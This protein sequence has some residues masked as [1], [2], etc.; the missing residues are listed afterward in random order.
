MTNRARACSFPVLLAMLVTG[1]AAAGSMPPAGQAEAGECVVLLH[2]LAR[3]KRSMARAEEIVRAYGYATVNVG[4]ASRSQ[5]VAKL[6]EA[7]VPAGVE[8]C[9]SRGARR[10]HFLAHSLGGILVRYHLSRHRIPE[11]GRVVMLAPP[12]QG[13]EAVDTLSGVPGYSLWYGPAGSELGTGAGSVPLGLGPVDYEVG[14]IAG[15]SSLN[16]LL[17]LIIPGDDDGK[18]SVARARLEGMADFLVVPR[19]HTFIMRNEEVILQAIHFL[20]QGRF[21]RGR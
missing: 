20:Q 14:V 2:G 3:T 6:A 12:N 10:I 1:G 15:S 18:V 11:L 16:P 13:S 21:F 4:Y 8:G 17:S 7:A 5:T 9:R 19:S